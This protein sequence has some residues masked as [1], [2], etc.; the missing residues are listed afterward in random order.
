MSSGD[1]GSILT[2]VFTAI[3]TVGTFLLWISTRKTTKLLTRELQNQVASNISIAH[4]NVLD[5]HRD[6]YLEII[7]DPYLLKTLAASMG[8]DEDEARTKFLGTLLINHSLRIF[9][10]YKYNLADSRS[11]DSF[12]RDVSDMFS[13]PF[14]R[15]RWEEVKKFHPPEFQIFIE[16]AI[17]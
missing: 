1:V 11:L 8:V 4:H 7:C 14:V 5:A 10:D 16:N 13:F 15:K 6:L 3:Y 17:V 12:Q 9:W 2:A